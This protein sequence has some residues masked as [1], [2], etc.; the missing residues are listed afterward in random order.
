MKTQGDGSWG[1]GSEPRRPEKE[2]RPR[3]PAQALAISSTLVVIFFLVHMLILFLVNP[4]NILNL[5]KLNAY[6]ISSIPLGMGLVFLVDAIT[7]F[8]RIEVH[9]GVHFVPFLL[10]IVFGGLSIQ[11]ILGCLIYVARHAPSF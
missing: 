1:Q 2:S 8:R 4:L 6:A 3:S 9:S 11:G 10:A 5:S 7:N